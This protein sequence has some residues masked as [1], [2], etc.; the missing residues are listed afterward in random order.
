LT[1]AVPSKKKALLG[2]SVVKRLNNVAE[3]FGRKGAL[4]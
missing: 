4:A 1:L 3:A 2:E